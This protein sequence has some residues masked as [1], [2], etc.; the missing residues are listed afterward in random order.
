M[1]SWGT[2]EYLGGILGEEVGEKYGV[3]RGGLVRSVCR[4][5]VD[6]VYR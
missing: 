4:R 6:R 3:V 2:R 1:S 5:W